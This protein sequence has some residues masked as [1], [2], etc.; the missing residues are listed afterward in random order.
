[1]YLNN[2]KAKA[3]KAKFYLYIEE[4]SPTSTQLCPCEAAPEVTS[5]NS[6]PARDLFLAWYAIAKYHQGAIAILTTENF[7]II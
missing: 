7:G 2:L 1:M 5:L 6:S 3:G 4:E